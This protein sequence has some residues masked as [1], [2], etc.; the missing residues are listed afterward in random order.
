MLSRDTPQGRFFAEQ[1]L[2][3]YRQ[4]HRLAAEDGAAAVDGLAALFAEAVGSRADVE[5]IIG[6]AKGEALTASIKRQIDAN[7][8][9]D[10]LTVDGICQRFQLSRASLYRL[11]EP[12]GGL[13]RYIQEE[14]LNRSFMRLISPASRENSGD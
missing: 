10:K 3:Y 7:L 8:Q 12:E 2:A 9:T 1:L 4:S 13:V 5:N 11:F 14:R 6:R